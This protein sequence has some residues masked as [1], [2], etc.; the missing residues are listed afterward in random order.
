MSLP[1]FTMRQLIESGVHFGHTT[2]R[3]NPKMK[4]YIYG[5]REGVHIIDLAQTAP[6]L[7]EALEVVKEVAAKGGRI[8]FV[9]TKKQAQEPVKEAA[10][11][12]GQY[13]V[14][15][16]WL[17][18]MMT[19]WKTIS[20]SIKRLKEINAKEEKGE[21]EALTKKERLNISRER[22]KLFNSLGGI[23]D[24]NGH[25]DLVF[26]IDTLKEAL[27]INESVCLGIPVIGICD[28]NSDPD[29]ITYKIPGND[30]AIRAINL[31]CD[32]ISSAVLDGIEEEMRKAGVDV[33]AKET[34]SVK[35]EAEE[36]SADEDVKEEADEETKK[37]APK[38]TKKVVKKTVK[39]TVKKEA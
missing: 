5:K 31:Y 34:V 29:K 35:V 18:G 16:R 6:M 23:Q 38:T 25:P 22:E 30:D 4:K 2:R 36:V 20:T 19:N 1:K 33:G 13:Y 37:E 15:H 3:W 21:F 39:K 10:L 11:R 17:G 28:T 14:N 24:M 9:G 7:Q 27:A 32:L 12:C 8:L 26:V